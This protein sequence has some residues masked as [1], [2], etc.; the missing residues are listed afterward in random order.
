MHSSTRGGQPPRPGR[1]HWV[2]TTRRSTRST[3]RR[4]GHTTYDPAL[5]RGATEQLEPGTDE[6]SITGELLTR[7]WRY[8]QDH[9]VR[10]LGVV[11]VRIL[12]AFELWSPNDERAAHGSRGLDVHGW[13]LGWA[14]F[15]A[16]LIAASFGL[17]R[18]RSQRR[19]FLAPLFLAPAA[20]AATAMVWF[21]DPLIRASIDP[22]LAIAAATGLSSLVSNLRSQGSLTGRA[23]S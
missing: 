11:A 16:L 21:G 13:L 4:W 17:W 2:P 14:S 3:D 7:G 8:A 12:R 15:M 10:F 5:V 19:G 6:A 9:P 22:I 20:V 18:L 23:S 1:W